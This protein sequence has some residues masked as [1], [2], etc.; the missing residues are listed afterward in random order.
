MLEYN[1]I[2]FSEGIDNKKYKET[3]RECSLSKFYFF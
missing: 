3:S 1:R 2:D